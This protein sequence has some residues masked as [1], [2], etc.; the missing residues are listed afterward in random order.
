M[1]YLHESDGRL[2][3]QKLEYNLVDHCNLACREC[4]HLSPY[5]RAH[6]QALETFARDLNRLAEV[7]RVG[8]FRFVGGEPLLNRDIGAF[9]KVVRQ[10]EIAQRIEVASNGTRLNALSDALLEQIDSVVLSLYPGCEPEPAHLERTRVRCAEAGVR[11][12]IERINRFRKSQPATPIGDADLVHDIYRS[13]LIAH[14]WSCQTIYDGSFYLCS[15][16]IY[17]D[18]YR[19]RMGQAPTGVK[20]RDGIAL[21]EPGLLQRLKGYLASPSPLAACQLCLGTV[22]KYDPH[23]QLT[24]KERRFPVLDTQPIDQKVDYARMRQLLR[25]QTVESAILRRVPSLR[26]SRAFSMAHTALIKELQ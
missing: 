16:P 13:C 8:R 6:S 18:A 24:A 5:M 11:L 9:V 23:T 10:S 17:A 26:L 4:S 22:G 25:W 3:A 1:P 15:R 21:H 2:H 19:R 20:Q 14:T 7:Y 12:R